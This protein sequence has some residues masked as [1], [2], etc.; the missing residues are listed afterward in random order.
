MHALVKDRHDADI[1]IRQ[2]APIH[3]MAFIAEA[4][5]IDAEISRHRPGQHTMRR[6]PA[7]SLEESLD[8]ALGLRGAE[9]LQGVAIDV[10]QAARRRFLDADGRHA[11]AL[12]RAITS[13]AVSGR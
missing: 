1:A 10:V 6:N 11:G 2:P 5:A 13:A 3:D 12:L 7:E 9:L 4:E 8:I